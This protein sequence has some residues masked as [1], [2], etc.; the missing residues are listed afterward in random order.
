MSAI[1][2]V[3]ARSYSGTNYIF[4]GCKDMTNEPLYFLTCCY[5][6]AVNVTFPEGA[7]GGGIEEETR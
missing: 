2:S 4:R 1:Y 6:G 7:V 3:V 5:E